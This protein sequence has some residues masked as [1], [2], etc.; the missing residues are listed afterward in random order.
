[1]KWMK[2]SRYHG[3][4]AVVNPPFFSCAHFHPPAVAFVRKKS[5]GSVRMCRPMGLCAAMQAGGK[6]AISFFHAIVALDW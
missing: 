1:M 4:R 5:A 2:Q 3:A 6:V